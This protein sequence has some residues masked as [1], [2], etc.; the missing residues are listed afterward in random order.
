MVACWYL[1][2]WKN[3]SIFEEDFH[4][5]NNPTNVVILKWG[6]RIL[7][8]VS[9]QEF[10]PQVFFSRIL[11]KFMNRITISYTIRYTIS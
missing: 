6:A 2:K 8:K 9:L 10:D 1:W 7:F 3:K 4:C 5:P 11:F